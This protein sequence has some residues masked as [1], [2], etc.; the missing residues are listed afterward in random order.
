MRMQ[1]G[2]AAV[3][4]L[5]AAVAQGR[6]SGPDVDGLEAYDLPTFTIVTRD[7]GAARP[8]PRLA[9]QLDGALAGLLGRDAPRRAAP[10]YV[11]IVPENLWL[12]FL[13]PGTGL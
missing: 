2:M 12:H 9:A 4:C 8:L 13:R 6:G 5:I 7:E 11:V 3:A 10:S 1:G